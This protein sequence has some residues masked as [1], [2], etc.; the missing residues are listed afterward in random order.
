MGLTT[1]ALHPIIAQ[2]SHVYVLALDAIDYARLRLSS[3][4]CSCSY[5]RRESCLNQRSTPLEHSQ[6]LRIT[7]PRKASWLVCDAGNIPYVTSHILPAPVKRYLHGQRSG[8]EERSRPQ[9]R[10]RSVMQTIP[11]S[12]AIDNLGQAPHPGRLLMRPDTFGGSRK[13][14][15]RC[16]IP[17]GSQP[18]P[19]PQ[20]REPHGQSAGDL[21]AW[22]RHHQEE[23]RDVLSVALLP[24]SQCEVL[25]R[26][27]TR[28]GGVAGPMDGVPRADPVGEPCDG[29]CV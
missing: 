9:K 22:C 8:G 19:N 24:D 17:L 18:C 16:D 14:C 28:M 23:P 13:R 3:P 2:D 15:L 10:R 5:F 6:F 12:W 27:S 29:S 1:I 26:A 4:S 25:S 20:C 7:A 21:C 11:V